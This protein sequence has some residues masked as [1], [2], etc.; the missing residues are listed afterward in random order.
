[1]GVV[2]YHYYAGFSGGRKMVVP[3]VSSYETIQQNHALVL[4]RTPLQGKNPDAAIGK[5]DDNP[6]HEDMIEAVGLAGHE[7]FFSVNLIVDSRQSPARLFCGDIVKAHRQGC[8]FVD[9]IYRARLKK[10]AD[11]AIVSAGGYPADINF[12][13][14]HKSIENASYALKDKGLMLVLS[15]CAEGVGSG[16]FRDWLKYRDIRRIESELRKK[17]VVS[18]HTALCAMMKS[19]RFDIHMLS[20]LNSNFVR[21]LNITPVSSLRRTL[22]DLFGRMTAESRVLIL[23]GGSGILPSVF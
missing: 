4:R 5:L 23:T 14:A 7:R 13:Q 6:V 3:G 1:V 2:G 22:S 17:F 11:F 8:D 19:E 20:G 21:S 16:V 15:E 9:S 12:V 18:G 10:R